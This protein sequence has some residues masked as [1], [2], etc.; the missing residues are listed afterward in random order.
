MD[1][2]KGLVIDRGDWEGNALWR[3]RRAGE[4]DASRGRKLARIGRCEGRFARIGTGEI[5]ERR[6]RLDRVL[7]VRDG[8]QILDVLPLERV[9]ERVVAFVQVAVD[10]RTVVA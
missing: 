9:G 2:G 1:G 8:A 4:H 5:G 7:V 10:E 6:G 3:T